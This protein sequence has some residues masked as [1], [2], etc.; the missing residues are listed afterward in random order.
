MAVE[1]TNLENLLEQIHRVSQ[2]CDRVS[3][4]RIMEATGKRSFGALLLLAGIILASPLSGIPGIPTTMAVLVLL[5]TVQLLVGKKH[6]WFP[7]WLLNRS[8]KKSQLEKAIR[9]LKP[10]ARFVDR[11]LKP[12]LTVF[13]RRFTTHVI[14][15]FC[16]FIALFM[17][18]MELVPF[19]ATSAGAALTAFGLSLVSRDGILVLAAIAFT[20][21]TMGLVL[22]NLF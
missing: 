17:P 22:F 12:R 2:A 4:G 19:S 10:P 16:V 6:F 3:L 21:L 13:A 5:I 1:P 9:W 8:I 7:E 15:V 14:A 20:G 18:V 11:W